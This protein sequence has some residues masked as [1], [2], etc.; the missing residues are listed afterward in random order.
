MR[1]LALSFL[2]FSI[3]GSVYSQ[4][5]RGMVNSNYSGIEGVF[6]NPANLADSRAKVEFNVLSGYVDANNNHIE[7]E[8]PY[9]QWKALRGNLPDHYLDSNGVA[10]YKNE[11]AKEN[12]NGKRKYVFASAH[13]TGPSFM[14]NLK[15]RSGFAF[16]NRTRVFAHVAGINEDL[17][18]IFLQDLDTT[19][20][21]YVHLQNQKRHIGARNTQSNFG[22]GASAFQEFDFS[23]ARVLHDKKENFVKGGVTLKYLIGMGAAHIQVNDM[24]YELVEEDS[25]HIY[26]ADLSVAYVNESYYENDELRLNDI[27]GKNKLANGFG[28]DIGVVY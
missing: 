20:A 5:P 23:Y 16:A 3:F 9:S 17:L 14:F 12:L 13:V 4:Y 11:Y 27:L 21:D 1:K 25:I 10:L 2:M 19:G 24:D 18:K 26:A 8:T 22:V 28:I 15:D 6:F 7:I